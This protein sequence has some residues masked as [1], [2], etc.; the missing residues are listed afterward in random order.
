MQSGIVINW[1]QNMLLKS[2]FYKHG[3]DS[4]VALY[5]LKAADIF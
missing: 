2:R 5:A 3:T 4:A 1:L